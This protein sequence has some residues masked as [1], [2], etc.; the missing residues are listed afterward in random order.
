M[1]DRDDRRPGRQT[2]PDAQDPLDERDEKRVSETAPEER[3]ERGP[4]TDR[5]FGA[6]VPAESDIPR[7]SDDND[8]NPEGGGLRETPL[9]EEY[10]AMARRDDLARRLE[11]LAVDAR[12]W[13]REEESDEARAIADLVADAYER[14]GAA[15]EDTDREGDWPQAETGDMGGPRQG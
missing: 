8:L 3:P 2:P 10:G 11:E 9:R 13:A 12:D 1:S 4:N 5:S 15:S 7:T 14:I 6:S